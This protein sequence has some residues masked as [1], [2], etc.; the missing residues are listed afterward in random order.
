MPQQIST[1]RREGSSGPIKEAA[2]SEYAM[3]IPVF[4]RLKGATDWV[5]YASG[6]AAEGAL[7]VDHRNIRRA[8]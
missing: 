4:S 2:P 5:R 8:S 3:T 6:M 1:G 7:D